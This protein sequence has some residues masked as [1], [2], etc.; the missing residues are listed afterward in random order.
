MPGKTFEPWSGSAI[1]LPSEIDWRVMPLDKWGQPWE[2]PLTKELRQAEFLM[3]Q[4]FP[5]QSVEMIGVRTDAVKSQ[6]DQALQMAA[7]QPMV[8]IRPDW[9]Y[10]NV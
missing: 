2:P 4:F 3:H 6:V 1:V 10:P 9:Y 5:W 7:H 8:D